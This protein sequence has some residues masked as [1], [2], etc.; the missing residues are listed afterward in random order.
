M[1]SGEYPIYPRTQ[2]SCYLIGG[3]QGALSLPDLRVWSHK[4][5]V[6]DW[7]APMSVTAEIRD[8]SDP[9]VNQIGHFAEV[10]RGRTAPIVSGAE[11]V[12]TLVVIE[13]IQSSGKTKTRIELPRSV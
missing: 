4:D 1:T 9:L 10:I 12:R 6:R 5:G 11:G 3:S 7:W 2:E 8:N 13:A